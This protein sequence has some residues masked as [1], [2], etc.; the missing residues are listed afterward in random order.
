MRQKEKEDAKREQLDEK[1]KR[2]AER[3]EIACCLLILTLCS[4]FAV[5]LLRLK[6][7]SRSL[8]LCREQ[9]SGQQLKQRL[10]SKS[11]FA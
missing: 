7:W 3:S 6:L 4:V 1:L 11:R 9:A 8:L 2:L 10:K 5:M